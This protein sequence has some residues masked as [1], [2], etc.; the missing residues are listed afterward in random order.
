MATTVQMTFPDDE[1]AREFIRAATAWDGTG[2]SYQRGCGIFYM[3]EGRNE[4][5]DTRMVD[6]EDVKVVG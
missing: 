5:E 2:D 3:P 1:E 6:V 4:A